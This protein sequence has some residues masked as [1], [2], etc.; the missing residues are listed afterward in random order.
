M[1]DRF[2]KKIVLTAISAVIFVPLLLDGLAY[3]STRQA[4][5]PIDPAA[6]HVTPAATAP[7]L[8][9]QHRQHI[10]Y[11]DNNGGGHLHGMGKACESE[12]PA[13]W[14]AEDITRTVTALAANDNLGWK[15]SSNGYEVAET[16]DS[17]VKIRI[18]VDRRRNL[19]VTAYPL[20]MPRHACPRGHGRPANDDLR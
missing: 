2:L 7:V 13:G 10:L 12:F 1:R 20:N 4:S 14:S 16:Y 5:G 15:Q 6:G 18:V 3:L 9:A 8:D 11:G 17:G 19:I